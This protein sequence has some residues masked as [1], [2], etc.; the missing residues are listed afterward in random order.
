MSKHLN[1]QDKQRLTQLR[2]EL[3]TN[4]R[5]GYPM[6]IDLDYRETYDLFDQHINN[7][8]DPFIDP[9]FDCHA[10]GMEREVIDFYADLFHAPKNDRWGY[11]TS[12]GTEGNLFGLYLGRKFYPDGIVYHTSASHYG[13]AKAVDLLNMP[14]QVIATQSNG[15]MDYDD[16]RRVVSANKDKPAIVLANIGT[17]MTEAKDN[18]AQIKK[19]LKA[20]DMPHFIHSDAAL[21]GI[22][23][24]QLAPHHPFDIRDGA[25]SISISGHKFVGAP[26]P[27]GIVITKRSHREKLGESI[28]YIGTQDT[29]ITGSRSGHAAILMWYAIKRW[30]IK[31]FMKRA[32][33]SFALADY[34]EEQL[35]SIEWNVWRNSQ[36]ITLVLAN[37]SATLRK[38]WQLA[39]Q[40]GW[41]HIICV[42]GLGR[43]QID[44]F[45]A[46]LKQDIS[47]LAIFNKL[48]DAFKKAA[49]G[50]K[51]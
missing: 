19:E 36:S 51:T 47:N 4:K 21:S 17:T 50:H 6:A 30:G 12:G 11:V 18:V 24:S 35:R 49:D 20:L 34:A 7:I 16:F 43:S 41:S 15:E 2:D 29:T 37:P 22:Y 9:V 13:V 3:R 39:S 8:G 32:E 42:P 26:F 1:A 14:S 45:I 48:P 25:D 38:K 23:L 10:K 33:Q 28:S 5:L 27:C 31:G 44:E 40:D 46:D